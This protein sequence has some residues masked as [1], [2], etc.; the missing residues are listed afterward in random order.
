M[1]GYC[2]ARRWGRAV[3]LSVEGVVL[4]YLVFKKSK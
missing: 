4:N 2:P 1:D 3:A